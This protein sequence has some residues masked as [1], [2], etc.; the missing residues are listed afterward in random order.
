MSVRERKHIEVSRKEILGG[1]GWKYVTILPRKQL[2][3]WRNCTSFK[4]HCKY[5]GGLVSW[6]TGA[7]SYL[8]ER[9]SC[10]RV[11]VPVTADVLCQMLHLWRHSSI[12]SDSPHSWHSVCA[13]HESWVQFAGCGMLGKWFQ[14]ITS[15]GEL[16]GVSSASGV[17]RDLYCFLYFKWFKQYT[18]AAACQVL[19]IGRNLED[20]R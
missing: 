8:C 15:T 10:M 9:C 14:G 11:L 16:L 12:F 19:C 18:L 2:R 17:Q 20:C 7:Q 6:E 5:F 4:G 3:V 1:K 13:M